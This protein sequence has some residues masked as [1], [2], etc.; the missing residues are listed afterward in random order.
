MLWT[1]SF[2]KLL[3]KDNVLLDFVSCVGNILYIQNKFAVNY[4]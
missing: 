4:I 3:S 1:L 2:Y